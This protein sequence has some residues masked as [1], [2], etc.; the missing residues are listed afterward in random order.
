MVKFSA[1][2]QTEHKKVLG[3]VETL[4]VINLPTLWSEGGEIRDLMSLISRT[5]STWIVSN[6][7]PPFGGFS[8]LY[9]SD[10]FE[11][12]TKMKKIILLTSAALILT[13]TSIT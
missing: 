12:G 8:F 13:D 1:I 5:I 4:N 11:K 7:R 9:L 6:F 2:L 3:G 10:F